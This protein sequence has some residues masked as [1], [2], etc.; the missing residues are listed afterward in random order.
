[1]AH[2][3]LVV[4]QLQFYMVLCPVGMGGSG[5]LA[6]GRDGGMIVHA[7]LQKDMGMKADCV[8][9]SKSLGYLQHCWCYSKWEQILSPA[10]M[11]SKDSTR[12]GVGEVLFHRRV[13]CRIQGPHMLCTSR[14]CLL[15]VGRPLNSAAS[16]GLWGGQGS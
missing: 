5:L 9:I 7:S 10:L 12:G 14:S 3:F 4:E 6:A 11:G 16:E 15:G 2:L 8:T 13:G 1:M